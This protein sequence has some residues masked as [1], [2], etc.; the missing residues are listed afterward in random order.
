MSPD[1][2][3]LAAAALTWRLREGEAA[4]RS[5]RS[6]LGAAASPQRVAGPAAVPQPSESFTQ[7]LYSCSVLVVLHRQCMYLEQTLCETGYKSKLC[8]SPEASCKRQ[9]II[10]LLALI[11]FLCTA[12]NAIS[13]II[14]ICRSLNDAC[15]AGK[16]LTE[17]DRT[18]ALCSACRR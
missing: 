7:M 18:L 11:A 4:H 6:R 16:L 2:A 9:P 10:S 15:V 3:G 8:S 5:P 12:L 17:L 1:R 13:T 14:V